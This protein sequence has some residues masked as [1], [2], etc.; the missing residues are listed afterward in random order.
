MVGAAKDTMIGDVEVRFVRICFGGCGTMA[1]AV[2][3]SLLWM[4]RRVYWGFVGAMRCN[5]HEKTN[6]CNGIIIIIN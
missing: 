4:W 6:N 2:A 1:T 3:A 5:C